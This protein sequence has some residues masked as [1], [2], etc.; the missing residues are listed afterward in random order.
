[1]AYESLLV[2]PILFAAAVPS[3]VAGNSRPEGLARFLFQ[4]YLLAV[5][6]LYF[7]WCWR[8]SGQTLPMKAWRLR[9]VRYD[10]APVELPRAIVRY[11]IAAPVLGAGAVGTILLWRQ[12]SAIH[13]LALAPA[14]IDILWSLVDERRQFLHD[15]L[16]GTRI[17]MVEKAPARVG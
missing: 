8:R 13:S 5:L 3:L 10:G 7:V 2:V 16:A 14:L 15:R 17:T 12:P 6:G 11:L 9:L 1:M 4:A